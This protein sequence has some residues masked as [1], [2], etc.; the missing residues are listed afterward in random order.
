MEDNR[1]PDPTLL[2]VN[3]RERIGKD[4]MVEALSMVM[5]ELKISQEHFSFI[6][7]SSGEFFSV[8]FSR[9]KLAALDARRVLASYC[10]Y[11]IYI[12]RAGGQCAL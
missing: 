11:W 8:R 9:G 4:D 7:P 5:G 12:C 6:G 3:A 1:D 10:A 2:R